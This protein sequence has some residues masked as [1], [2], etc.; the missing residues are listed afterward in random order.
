MKTSLNSLLKKGLEKGRLSYGL[1]PFIALGLIV[2]HQVFLNLPEKDERPIFSI[3]GT[4]DEVEENLGIVFAVENGEGKIGDEFAMR[5][6]LKN[7]GEVDY[8]N[9]FNPPFSDVYIY[10]DE[11]VRMANWSDGRQFRK[12]LFLI[13]LKPG[14]GFI[15][16]KV[17][18]LTVHNST[19]GEM[20]PLGVGRYWLSGVWLG[21][22]FIESGKILL[23]IG[24]P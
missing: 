9:R 8:V 15:E 1:I 14:D 10:D 7:M 13:V 12:N 18:D 5:L 2:I 4:S 16:T 22:P 23:M 20:E 17:W 6:T 21:K 11:G 19:S 24:E 3:T